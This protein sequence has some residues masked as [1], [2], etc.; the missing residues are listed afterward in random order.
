MKKW[1]AMLCIAAM[2]L[3]FGAC[4]KDAPQGTVT[5]TDGGQETTDAAQPQGE[6][7]SLRIVDGAGTGIFTLAG[8]DASAVYTASADELTVYL[9][10]SLASPADLRNGMTLTVEPGYELLETWPAQFAG[11]TVYADS[12]EK[13]GYGDLCGLY[14]TVL[15]DLWTD[16]SALNENITYI[17]VDLTDAPGALTDGE[18]AAVAWLFSG[19]HNAQPL[20]F[21]FE[22]LKENGFVN[23]AELYW[24]DGAL[25]SIKASDHAKQSAK[26]I[27]FDAEKWRSGTGAIFFTDCTAKR[28]KDAA[29]DGY[30]PGGY[31]IS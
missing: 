16:D 22:A 30:K 18:I 26:K 19:R 2:L 21:G 11:A 28:G 29:W 13:D 7:L 14:L 4:K 10:G 6:P 27:T 17:S 20:T 31:A 5:A 1:I 24:P 8:E 12:A 15:E 3:A 25:F 9:D 23:E